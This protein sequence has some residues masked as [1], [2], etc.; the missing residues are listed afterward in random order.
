MNPEE[1]ILNSLHH[2]SAQRCARR[3]WLRL[4]ASASAG[5][6]IY[7]LT[8]DTRRLRA[9]T[10]QGDLGILDAQGETVELSVA[11]DADGPAELLLIAGEPLNEPVARYGP[12]V[13]NTRA[14]IIQA[15]EDYK[16]GRFGRIGSS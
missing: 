2:R 11:A 7:L 4:A 1:L 12:F 16:T 15:V 6:A 14:E 5:A 3:T 13:M 8:G 9:Q 10:T